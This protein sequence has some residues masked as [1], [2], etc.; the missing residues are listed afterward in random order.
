MTTE[1]PTYLAALADDVRRLE[2]FLATSHAPAA[3][4]GEPGYPFPALDRALFRDSPLH[5]RPAL[6]PGSAF[7]VAAARD[8]VSRAAMRR[9][10]SCSIN[11]IG[12]SD[13]SQVALLKLVEEAADMRIL[14]YVAEWP[15]IIE[16]LYS[17]CVTVVLPPAGPD[18][19]AAVLSEAG[20][21]HDRID[22]LGEFYP[23]SIRDALHETSVDRA[24]VDEL[25]SALAV[26]DPVRAIAA[27]R[28]FTT[29]HAEILGLSLERHLS[30]TTRLPALAP[31]PAAVLASWA[32]VLSLSSR[33]PSAGL[34]AR[35]GIAEVL[36]AA[37]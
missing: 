32:S 33:G 14:L 25:L 17:R 37:A 30:G 8:L 22:R 9:F 20:V 26:R 31:F 19:R 7:S 3:V 11:L 1:A 13:E 10:L 35:W 4:F 27:T 21:S 34:A 16:P 28:A 29:A 5:L 12:A 2:D 6:S 23:G 36:G 18:L 15:G 24:P